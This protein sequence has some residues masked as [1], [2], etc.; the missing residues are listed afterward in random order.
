MIAISFPLGIYMK[1]VYENERTLAAY[2]IRK[3]KK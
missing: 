3:D 2:N 1:K